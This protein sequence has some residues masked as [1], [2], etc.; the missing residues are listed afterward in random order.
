[1]STEFVGG[2]IT[3]QGLE[4]LAP[5]SSVL[6][7]TNPQLQ[8]VNF[9]RRGYMVV[10]AGPRELKVQ[11]RSPQSVMVP[12]SP[13]ET[14]ASFVVESGKPAVQWPE[15]LARFA[16]SLARLREITPRFAPRR[17][18]AA[19]VAGMGTKNDGLERLEE[20]GT[21]GVAVLRAPEDVWMR[22]RPR[23]S[24]ECV[25]VRLEHVWMRD[26]IVEAS[27]RWYGLIRGSIALPLA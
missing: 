17:V 20:V 11:Y 2:S 22:T 24:V 3:S 26:W 25:F 9:T 12:K 23:R 10:E 21:G 1:V 16:P 7:V 13:V 5:V 15:G 19:M 14:L 27:A 8:Y 6:R 4:A 18:S